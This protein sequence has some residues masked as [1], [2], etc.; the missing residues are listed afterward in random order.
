MSTE[1]EPG[2]KRIV[3]RFIRDGT[4]HRAPWRW[5]DQAGAALRSDAERQCASPAD[6]RH[7][8]QI[9]AA[10]TAQVVAPGEGLTDDAL[11][12]NLITQSARQAE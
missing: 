10:Q 11:R 6:A 1:F 2:D 7:P 5:A 8:R 12:W 4:N 9:Q 3:W